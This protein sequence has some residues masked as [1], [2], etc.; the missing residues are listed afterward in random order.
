VWTTQAKTLEGFLRKVLFTVGTTIEFD[1]HFAGFSSSGETSED[2]HE[3]QLQLEGSISFALGAASTREAFLA[4]SSW[5]QVALRQRLIRI[6]NQGC[7]ATPRLATLCFGDKRRAASLLA[8]LGEG[9]TH[10]EGSSGGG[11]VGA[12]AGAV[13]V[14]ANGSRS[15]H[16]FD[17]LVGCDGSRSEVRQASGVEV[18]QRDEATVLRSDGTRHQS[19]LTTRRLRAR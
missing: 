8:G 14:A 1:T 11:A 13:I 9:S 3:F 2:D 17:V 5:K 7:P 16:E 10:L 18:V 4:L 19:G 6:S 12:A 15:V